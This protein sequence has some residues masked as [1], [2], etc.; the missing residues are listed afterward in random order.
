VRSTNAKN[1]GLYPGNYYLFDGSAPAP[2]GAEAK[3][4]PKREVKT[5]SFEGKLWNGWVL[6]AT[7]ADD[8]FVA[9]AAAYRQ[10][11]ESDDPDKGL[12]ATR[13]TY[14]GL[15]LRTQNEMLRH[16]TE[17]AEG[18]LW[19]D[20]LRRKMGDDAFFKLVSDYFAANTTKTVTAASFVEKAGTPFAAPEAGDGPAYLTTDIGRR[21]DTAV[22]VYGTD[23]E[24]GTNRYVAEQLQ[25]RYLDQ[26][27]SKIAVVKDFDATDDL[28]RDRDVIFVGR[29]ETNSALAAW[30]DKLGLKYTGAVFEADGATYA[31]EREALLWA[32]KNPLDASHMALVVAGNDPLRTVKAMRA[33]D[34]T[35][36]AVFEDGAPM[37][38]RARRRR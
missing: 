32:A 28:L 1:D 11:L 38:A 24:A 16:A 25:A 18:V 27:E 23:R 15:K 9:G 17:Q 7:A 34:S 3:A 14:R 37:P 20:G 10:L 36:Y 6:P 30:A 26:Y 12:E 31:S 22:I 21:L 2:Q 4:A 33:Q 19:L 5:T 13:I 35:P 29:P 8:W